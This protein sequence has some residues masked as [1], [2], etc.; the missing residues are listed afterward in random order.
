MPSPSGS[1]T[2]R[3]L[4]ACT[5]KAM[6]FAQPSNS[7]TAMPAVN[8]LTRSG[9]NPPLGCFRPGKRKPCRMCSYT[10]LPGAWAGLLQRLPTGRVQQQAP[11]CDSRLAMPSNSTMQPPA[12]INHDFPWHNIIRRGTEPGVQLCQIF[13]QMQRQLLH[14]QLP[15]LCTAVCPPGAGFHT[16][17]CRQEVSR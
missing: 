11:T 5:E 10:S 4:R 15:L 6:P 14:T 1:S 2:E 7:S 9:K 8:A 16:G 3:Y 12:M 17:G 13:G